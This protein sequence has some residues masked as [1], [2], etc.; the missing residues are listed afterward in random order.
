MEILGVIIIGI[1]VGLFLIVYIPVV[2][3]LLGMMLVVMVFVLIISQIAGLPVT[4][5]QNGKVIGH[6]IKFKYVEKL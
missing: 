2:L 1:L 3:I 5:T 4:V 6:L